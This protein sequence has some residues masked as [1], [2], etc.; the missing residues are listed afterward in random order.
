MGIPPDTP[1]PGS[2]APSYEDLLELIASLRSQVA[3]LEARIADLEQ[4]LGRNPRNS[5][6]PPSKEGL[7]EP[8]RL[9]RS[10]RNAAGRRQAKQRGTPGA[11]LCQVA[12]PDEVI[13]HSPKACTGCGADLV[14]AEVASTERRQV[15]DLSAV[16]PFVTE[17]RIERR[18]CCC[19]CETKAP[20]PDQATAPAT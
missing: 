19:G 3:T 16:R 17:H 1:S 4:R 13:T 6:M 5:S 10:E 8:S 12:D 7:G 14:A 15:F 11:N 20:V 2:A 18:R 9:P